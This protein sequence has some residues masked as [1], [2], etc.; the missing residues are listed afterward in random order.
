MSWPRIAAYYLGAALVGAFL[1]LGGA[2]G[3]EGSA[4]GAPPADVPM[5][6]LPAADIER[7]SVRTADIEA[8]L[9]REGGRWKVTSPAGSSLPGDLVE[10]ILDTLT[11]IA[12]IETV[13][14]TAGRTDQYGLDPALLTVALAGGGGSPVV[15]EFGKRNPTGT[16][17]YARKQGESEVRL[18]GLNARYYLDLL[19]EDLRGQL[20][21][22]PAR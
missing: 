22:R 4:T 12:P 6:G 14:D 15:V 7:V 20:V 19:L 9:L 18:L 10:A 2:G 17:V 5:I 1:L 16:A 8:V 13:S 11:S 3:P 21:A